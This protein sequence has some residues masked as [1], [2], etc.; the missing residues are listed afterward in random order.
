MQKWTNSGT[1]VPAIREVPVLLGTPLVGWGGALETPPAPPTV[2]EQLIVTAVEENAAQP[3]DNGNLEG[4]DDNELLIPL[5]THSA[6]E[7]LASRVAYPDA[8]TQGMKSCWSELRVAPLAFVVVPS[9]VEY[10][11][12]I[13]Q[14]VWYVSSS[15]V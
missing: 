7:G 9:H 10:S 13:S 5:E 3:Q 11:C 6:P 12:C 4:E 14:V 1:H 8:L 2:T 15:L